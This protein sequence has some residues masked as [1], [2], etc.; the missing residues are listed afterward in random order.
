MSLPTG[1]RQGVDVSNLSLSGTG[2]GR[3]SALVVAGLWVRVVSC[4]PDECGEQSV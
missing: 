1:A 3:V 4:D 2:L